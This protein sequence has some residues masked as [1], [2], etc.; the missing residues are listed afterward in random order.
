MRGSDPMP[1]RTC[2]MSAPS[3]SA[4]FAIS[5]MNEMRV[6][7][8]ALAAYLV[9][10]AE[11]TSI[12]SSRSRLRWNGAYTARSS[13]IA[14]SSSAPIDDAVGP[15]EVLDRGAFLQE[16]RIRHDGKRQRGAAGGKL[17]G[18]RLANA[19]GG[20]DGNGRFVDDDLVVGH[21]AADRGRGVEDVPHVGR[22]VLVGRRADGDELKTAVRH[23]GVDV[24]REAQAPRIDVAMDHVLQSRLVDRHAA[25][26]EHV[27]LA[28]VDVEAKHVVADF[29][30][31]GAGDESRRILFRSS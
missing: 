24:G 28:C 8:I 21:A 10:S 5:F 27:D 17:G 19:I 12:T 23:R 14:R 1:W 31:A 25:R 9:S 4:R 29:G 16:F 13:A 22:A 3:S 20:A 7:S 6:A 15:H 11:R 26:L 2:S 18:D 30:E